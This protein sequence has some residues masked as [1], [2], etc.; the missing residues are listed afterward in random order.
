MTKPKPTLSI[1]IVSYNTK[2]L[3][4]N[5]LDT[6]YQKLPSDQELIIVDNASTD[7]SSAYI[8][9]HYPKAKLIKNSENLG[10][11]KAN[12]QAIKVASGKYLLLLNSD[13]LVKP[14]AFD[15]LIKFMDAH[16]KTGIASPQLL[17]SDG[18][19]QPGGGALPR[20]SNVFAWMFFIDD[21]PILGPLIPAYQR[22]Q[23]NFYKTTKKI[24]WVA[25]TAMIIRRSCLDQIGLLDENIFMYGEDTDLCIRAARSS[26]SRYIVADAQVTHLGQGS[27][28][29]DKALV[30]EFRGLIYLFAKHKP[31]WE[32]PLLRIILYIGAT[33]RLII[34]GTILGNAQKTKAYHQ[35]RK[36][37]R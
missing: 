11:A 32:P 16:P 2:T 36:L 26:W 10:F 31:A 29:Q 20:L 21:L 4:K 14:G 19:I 15:Q 6:F 8:K 30:G 9:K 25:G 37:V 28:S 35:A 1:I 12:N 18:S 3:L 7:G 24:G 33:L 13:T 17:N 27:G 34:F 5:C 23:P 22:S